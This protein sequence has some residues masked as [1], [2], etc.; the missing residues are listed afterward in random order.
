MRSLEQ[1]GLFG[2]NHT[3]DKSELTLE[4]WF[5]TDDNVSY[6]SLTTPTLTPEGHLPE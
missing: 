2:Q 3:R 6:I 4:A 5:Y 1:G